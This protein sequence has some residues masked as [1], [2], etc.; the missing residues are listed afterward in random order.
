MKESL[1]I[2]ASDATDAARRVVPLDQN[3][4]L[5]PGCTDVVLMTQTRD[6][7]LLM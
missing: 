5:Y 4:M 2:M 1:V 7:L 6:L 3:I